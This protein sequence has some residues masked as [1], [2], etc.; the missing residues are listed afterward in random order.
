MPRIW[1]DSLYLGDWHLP[2]GRVFSCDEQEMRHF[3]TRAKE[4]L[5]TGGPLPW[6]FEHDPDVGLSSV[7]RA[8]RQ[9]ENAGGHCHAVRL[10]PDGQLQFEVDVED[11]D[12][13]KLRKNKFVSPEIR[14]DV[15]DSHGKLWPGAS[16]VHLA[17]TPRPVQ[18][19]QKP[20]EFDPL[21]PP[22]LRLS[23]AG[24]TISLS[25][26]GHAPPKG[27]P[28]PF[29]PKADDAEPDTDD[30]EDIGSE[31]TATPVPDA[32]GRGDGDGG[33][34]AAETAAIHDLTT[35]IGTL[36]VQV[37]SS[38]GQ[39]LLTFVQHVISAIKTHKATKDGGADAGANNPTSTDQ[40]PPGPNEPLPEIAETPPVM[41]SQAQATALTTENAALKKT[42]ESTQRQAA[43]ADLVALCSAGH[44]SRDH[45]NDLVAKLRT[46]SLSAAGTLTGDVMAEIAALKRLAAD[47]KLN[48]FAKPRGGV[49][50]SQA[51]LDGEVAESVPGSATDYKAQED[52]GEELANLCG[53]TT[54]K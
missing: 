32:D 22:P 13:P 19:P 10:G 23:Q 20:F 49:S 30:L 6:C 3:H 18:W 29:P 47:G 34:N 50:L 12:V 17:V 25:S 37:H 48:S 27:K 28:M 46:V 39:D 41:M 44:I 2:D 14:F 4:M 51:G 36:G 24:V 7:Q 16:I 33:K 21:N 35:E 45:A 52:A 54:K 26:A 38:A 11:D 1:K 5:A 40:P 9:A 42:L 43:R 8:K 15:V 31:E 53:V